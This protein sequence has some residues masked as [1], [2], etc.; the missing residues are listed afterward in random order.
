MARMPEVALR[1]LS[2]GTRTVIP[3]QSSPELVTRKPEGRGAGSLPSPSPRTPEDISHITHPSVQQP[4]CELPT[5]PQTGKG[6]ST[7]IG[8][9]GRVAGD[10]RNVLRRTWRGGKEWPGPTCLWLSSNELWRTLCWGDGARAHREGSECHLW[11]ACHRFTTTG[12]EPPR[13]QYEVFSSPFSINPS[14]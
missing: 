6:G 13:P 7:P 10:V 12:L 3:A 4:T 14:R 2:V 9:L 1:A 5:L 8:L 11:H